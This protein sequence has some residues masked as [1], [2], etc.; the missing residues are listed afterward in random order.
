MTTP[1]SHRHRTQT[2]RHR[3][4][5]WQSAFSCVIICDSC[6]EQ[7]SPVSV[8]NDADL[9]LALS[10]RS[11]LNWSGTGRDSVQSPSW[12]DAA[13]LDCAYISPKTIFVFCL[14]SRKENKRCSVV[15]LLTIHSCHRLDSLPTLL[16]HRHVAYN[17]VLRLVYVFLF[18]VVVLNTPAV[19]LSKTGSN[20]K[21][22]KS[23][24]F[25]TRRVVQMLFECSD[26]VNKSVFPLLPEHSLISTTFA[27][28]HRADASHAREWS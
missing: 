13:F 18:L 25:T 16:T 17:A 12:T 7:K 26:C 23:K 22:V 14:S 20:F 1:R 3:R 11:V 27:R 19:K 28:Q 6:A 8:D 9:Q 2:R 24:R 21:N 10:S 4:Q 15:S 5:Y